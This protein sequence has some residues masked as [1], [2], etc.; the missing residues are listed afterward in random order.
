MPSKSKVHIAGVGSSPS[1]A[2]SSSSE[3]VIASLVSAGTKALLDAGLT[4]DS[5]SRGVRSKSS[6]DASQAFKAFDDEGITVDEVEAGA[7]LDSAFRSVQESGAQ[8]VLVIVGEK[9]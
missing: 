2:S 7:E 3:A 1:P 5:I 8:C 6:K 9:V 4:F